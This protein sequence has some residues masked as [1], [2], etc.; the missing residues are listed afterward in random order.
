[1][2]SQGDR[3]NGMARRIPRHWN[4]EYIKGEVHQ[5][6]APDE[7]Y[8]PL[9]PRKGSPRR[10]M[11]FTFVLLENMGQQA[12]ANIFHLNGDPLPA[13]VVNNVTIPWIVKNTLGDFTFLQAGDDGI[14]YYDER[15]GE[16]F[17][18]AIHPEESIASSTYLAVFQL[19]TNL[20]S[21]IGATAGA[22]VVVTTDPS[23]TAGSSIVVYNTGGSRSYLGLYGL[24]IK[25]AG[26][27]W[28]S[29]VDQHCL[30]FYATLNS[31][32]H[33][34]VVSEG[35]VPGSIATQVPTILFRDPEV[36]T[37]YPFSY[38][39][40]SQQ[41]DGDYQGLTI[42]NPK[43][44]FGKAGDTVLVVHKRST[45]VNE[46]VNLFPQFTRSFY[47]K[48]NVDVPS[49]LTPTVSSNA[50]YVSPLGAVGEI[51]NS[52]FATDSYYK[53]HNGKTG[54]RALL[55]KNLITG[56]WE[57]L[58]CEHDATTVK[59]DVVS[60]FGKNAAT[61]QLQNL[62][63]INGKQPTAPITVQNTFKY[64]LK[65]GDP[66][67]V[68][69]NNLNLTWI[70]VEA[71]QIGGVEDIEYTISSV[72]ISSN[73]DYNG[74]KVANVTIHG[75]PASLIGTGALVYDHSGCIFEMENM[76]GYT[77][78][79][80]WTRYRSLDTSKPCT[81]LTP[82][83]WAAFNRCCAPDSGEYRTC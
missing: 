4:D 51:P 48:F 79:G 19:T 6:W 72:T 7:E 39:P 29:I 69:W 33:N 41:E 70:P 11:M 12:T 50:L 16:P 68:R 82:F 66:V 15:D 23:L 18:Y 83:H 49:G 60:D 43:N 75:G 61:F 55:I 45:N 44:F 73:P 78:W 14:C 46:I 30:Q 22:Q 2:A 20:A 34:L 65:A 37:P 74:L 36:L 52:A 77:G 54:D 24:A 17:F 57:V 35:H 13:R 9:N 67:V 63:G 27:W 32:T 71:E 25:T 80:T 5:S 10:D 40:G 42:T 81:D 8:Y 56:N 26:Q 21:G 58:E 31:N 38:L 3:Q 64:E 62:V 59:G 47:A 1:M 53:A 28:I 76:E